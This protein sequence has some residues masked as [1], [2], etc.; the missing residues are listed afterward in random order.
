[1]QGHFYEAVNGAGRAKRVEEARSNGLRKVLRCKT[2]AY[3]ISYFEKSYI[4][5][6]FVP[7]FYK[8]KHKHTV[9]G[10]IIPQN[11]KKIKPLF[12]FFVSRRIIP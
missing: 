1:L 5:L 6:Q 10:I 2:S 9:C 4:L 3:I 8:A 7:V 12:R 11:K